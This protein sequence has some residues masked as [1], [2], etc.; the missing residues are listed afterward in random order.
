[1]YNVR[2]SCEHRKKCVMVVC[3]VLAC[4]EG[5][6]LLYL[7]YLDIGD[8]ELRE[9]SLS[10]VQYTPWH[11]SCLN[12]LSCLSCHCGWRSL[13]FSRTQ[14]FSTA[15]C[16]DTSVRKRLAWRPASWWAR[17]VKRI[18]KGSC[19]HKIGNQG[20]PLNASK[21]ILRKTRNHNM[22]TTNNTSC[23]SSI[24]YYSHLYSHLLCN[25]CSSC[26]SNFCPF[27]YS[28]YQPGALQRLLDEELRGAAAGAARTPAAHGRACTIAACSCTRRHRGEGATLPRCR[29]RSHGNFWRVFHG[30]P[31]SLCSG[32]L[33]L[34][35][36]W[37]SSWCE[38]FSCALVSQAARQSFRLSPK[39]WSTH[40]TVY[41]TIYQYIYQYIYIS[42]YIYISL[43]PENSVEN[44]TWKLAGAGA[45]AYS[46]PSQSRAGSSTPGGI[47]NA[48][49]QLFGRKSYELL[50][51]TNTYI[52]VYSLYNII[53]I[54]MFYLLAE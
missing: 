27:S 15:F 35:R 54:H 8:W 11:L 7:T 46:K 40:Y 4:L 17:I 36:P 24:P 37:F 51:D 16:T 21:S 13:Q 41:I 23:A 2:I 9:L 29:G 32:E 12:C 5:K 47:G 6:L 33:L 45:H 52:I 20:D 43:Y 30:F 14:T 38:S 48:M 49:Y 1:M 3:T 26:S 44:P 50:T 34:V 25:I 18:A 53:N 22:I 10:L 42:V 31:I 19:F 28:I 39:S